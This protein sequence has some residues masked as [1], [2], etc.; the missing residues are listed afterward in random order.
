M[1]G[2]QIIFGQRSS[3]PKT[4][5]SVSEPW[6]DS[7]AGQRITPCPTNNGKEGR[8]DVLGEFTRGDVESRQ[9]FLDQRR[10]VGALV[11]WNAW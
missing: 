7:G 1:G 3:I 11:N 9:D 2:E 4:R 6:N 5:Q 8:A 10:T